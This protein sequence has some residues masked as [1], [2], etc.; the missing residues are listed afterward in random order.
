MDYENALR[1]NRDPTQGNGRIDIMGPIVDQFQLFE[2]PE[3]QYKNVTSYHDALTGN[4]EESLLSQAFFSRENIIIIQNAIKR[5][6]YEGSNGRFIIAPQDETNLKIVMRSIFLQNARNLPEN[7]TQQIVELNK[8]VYEYAVPN[9]LSTATSYIKYKNDVSTLP[10]PEARP[11][12]VST[13]GD[14]QLEL[15]PFL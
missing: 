3:N 2:N 1:D 12:F 7:V 14:K 8:K 9:I 10:V 4:W 5:M 13:K 15:K 11:A 6:V